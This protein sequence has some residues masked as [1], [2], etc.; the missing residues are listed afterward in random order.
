MSDDYY[1]P[2]DRDYYSSQHNRGD[3]YHQRSYGHGYDDRY[4]PRERYDTRACQP[5]TRGYERLPSPRGYEQRRYGDRYDDRPS[6]GFVF[7]GKQIIVGT[8]LHV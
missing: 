4:D 6:S 3:G 7:R 5:P 2:R 8:F 1:R